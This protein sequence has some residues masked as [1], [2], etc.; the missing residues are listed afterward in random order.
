M[1]TILQTCFKLCIASYFIH[2]L[3]FLPFEWRAV[4][5]LQRSPARRYTPPLYHS[6]LFSKI[7][8]FLTYSFTQSYQLTRN[9]S[10]HTQTTDSY[11]F[12]HKLMYTHCCQNIV[13]TLQYVLGNAYMAYK[14]MGLGEERLPEPYHFSS[15]Q[16]D[17][18]VGRLSIS[19]P[20]LFSLLQ[21][22][23]NTEKL[24]A[25]PELPPNALN[26]HRRIK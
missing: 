24:W 14:I 8:F 4:T 23:W 19:L 22:T 25:Q 2:L 16:L 10:P 17:Q 5:G 18:R 21:G 3:R 15:H 7:L 12:R 11:K 6:S 20:C 26:Y 1:L 13:L 9:R